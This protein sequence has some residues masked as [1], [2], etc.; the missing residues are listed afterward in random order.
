MATIRGHQT[1]V[2]TLQNGQPVDIVTVTSFD[3]KQDATFMRSKF[4]GN[5]VPEG[6]V[7]EEGW[8]GTM[9]M[10]TQ[11]AHLEDLV[12]ALVTQNLNGVGVD[13][14]Q[15]VDTENYSDG[16]NRSYGYFDVQ[17]KMSKKAGSM[18]DK[19]KKTLDWQASGRLK[20]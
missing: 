1:Q 13:Q 6:D 12:D 20:L 11:D 18:S 19:V 5:P 2:K 17:C 3:A 9:E 7:A 15:I 4:V 8:S 10:E 14:V 16:T